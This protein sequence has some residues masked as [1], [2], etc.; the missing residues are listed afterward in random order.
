VSAEKV[1]DNYFFNLFASME[2]LKIILVILF[3]L[4]VLTI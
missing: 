4:E 1:R 2:L 3:I